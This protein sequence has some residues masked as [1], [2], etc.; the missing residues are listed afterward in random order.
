MLRETAMEWEWAPFF[1]SV[2]EFYG[3]RIISTPEDGNIDD[4]LFRTLTLDGDENDKLPFLEILKGPEK[5]LRTI[6]DATVG[7]QL[8]LTEDGRI[9]LGPRGLQK[10][11]KVA[12]VLGCHVPLIFRTTWYFTNLKSKFYVKCDA[13]EVVGTCCALGCANSAK[14]FEP[15]YS[16]VGEACE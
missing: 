1:S 3:K 16:L 10:H 15:K 6:H 9:G 2:G 13:H 8:F 5:L 14:V 12:I 4:I 11:D 7:R